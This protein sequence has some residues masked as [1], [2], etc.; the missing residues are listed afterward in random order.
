MAEARPSAFGD[1]FGQKIDLTAR[2]REI[3]VNYPP[4]STIIK[5]FLQNADDAGAGVV[6]LC[7]DER[8]FGTASLA[9]EKLAQ[10]QGPA[11]LVYNDGVFSDEDFDS[12]QSIGDSKKRGQLAKTGR[13]GIGFN[14]CYHLTEVPTFLSRSFLV[15]FDPQAKFLPDVNPANP[16]KR[17]DILSSTVQQHFTDQIAPYAAFGSDLKSQFNGTLFRLP[18]RTAE[19]ATSSRLSTK[20]HTTDDLLSLLRYAGAVRSLSSRNTHRSNTHA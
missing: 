14:S 11:L 9:H 15:M 12:I 6:K 4:G 2:I 18:L 3:L 10:F 19:Q 13:F 17:I 7:V 5:E 8:S 1:D 20:I 16:G